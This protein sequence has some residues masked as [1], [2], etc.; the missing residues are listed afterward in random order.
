MKN[1]WFWFFQKKNTKEWFCQNQVSKIKSGSG[2]VLTNWN[3]KGWF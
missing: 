2:P 1:L 3:G